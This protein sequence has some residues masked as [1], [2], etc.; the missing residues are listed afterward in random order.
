[1]TIRLV[2]ATLLSC[3]LGSLVAIPAT[4][5]SGQA[6][7]TPLPTTAVPDGGE[8]RTPAVAVCHDPALPPEATAAMA[9]CGDVTVPDGALIW[10]SDGRASSEFGWR[11]GR[12]HNGIDLAAPSGTPILA[13]D[14][15]HVV[16]AGWKGGYGRTV[17]IDHGDGVV[18]RYAHQSELHVSDGQRVTRGQRIGDVGTT[19]S[20]TGPHLHFEVE[21]DGEPV[22]PREELPDAA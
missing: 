11:G 9:A 3:T 16:F 10:P 12:M 4:A 5:A 21:I 7:V 14:D 2:T 13:A 19:G 15:G 6:P 8:P 18:T 1:M 22:D 20:S 17:D